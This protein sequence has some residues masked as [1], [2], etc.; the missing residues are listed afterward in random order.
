MRLFGNVTA[1]NVMLAGCTILARLLFVQSR[2][3]APMADPKDPTLVI[4]GQ[5]IIVLGNAG[6]PGQ[7][8][9][10]ET[11]TANHEL[12]LTTLLKESTDLAVGDSEVEH[13]FD[14]EGL[15]GYTGKFNDKVLNEIRK[16]PEVE[17]VEPDQI[18]YALDMIEGQTRKQH[19][20]SLLN[21]NAK[22]RESKTL[23][24]GREIR[25]GQRRFRGIKNIVK[26][27]DA[28][29]GISRGSH[30]EMPG[31]LNKYHYPKTAATNCRNCTSRG[32]FKCKM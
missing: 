21:S 3:L 28:P 5:Y 18:M 11:V 14:I 12:W 22:K 25:K 8:A 23:T 29:W 7:Q 31:Q 17:Y 13:Y 19:L 26:Q 24:K 6:Q 15:F 16:R 9:N 27:I 30:G 32:R 20:K 1:R 10:A 4:P 2:I